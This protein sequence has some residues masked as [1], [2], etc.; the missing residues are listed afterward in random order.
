MQSQKYQRLE[1][2]DLKQ[3]ATWQFQEIVVTF[4]MDHTMAYLDGAFVSKQRIGLE[5]YKQV[6]EHKFLVELVIS[7][8]ILNFKNPRGFQNGLNA[9]FQM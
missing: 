1:D 6:M 3:I 8:N 7:S 4:F 5:K 9:K 2:N